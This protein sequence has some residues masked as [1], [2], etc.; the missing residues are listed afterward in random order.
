MGCIIFIF[1]LLLGRAYNN[2]KKA[3]FL[4]KLLFRA[5]KTLDKK[6]DIKG[7]RK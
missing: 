2:A 6:S 7:E 5:G 3:L 4:E 1:P